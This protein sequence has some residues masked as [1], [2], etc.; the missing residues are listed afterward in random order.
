MVSAA[1]VKAE[2]LDESM[3]NDHEAIQRATEKLLEYFSENS[4][5]L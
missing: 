2:L 5:C 1:L 4:K 3:A